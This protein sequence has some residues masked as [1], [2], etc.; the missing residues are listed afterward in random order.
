MSYFGYP[1]SLRPTS[2]INYLS[3]LAHAGVT[4]L[5]YAC[6]TWL[7]TKA[8]DWQQH[9]QEWSGGVSEDFE[10]G[11]WGGHFANVC[12]A[13]ASW[14]QFVREHFGAFIDQYKLSGLYMDN[15]QVY[16]TYACLNSGNW[17]D[18]IEYPMLDQRD[19]YRFIILLR[20]NSSHTFALVHSSGGVN[21]P[22]F[23]MVDAWVSGEQY[24]GIVRNDYLDVASLTDFRIEL[25][26]AQWG[27]VPLFL[28]EFSDAVAREVAPT[29]K[30]M[31]IL[32][33]HDV[34]PWPQ[35]ANV[36][37][38]N[39]GLS[40][41]DAFGIEDAVFI[42][43]YAEKPVASVSKLGLYVSGYRH[44][45]TTLMIVANLSKATL[46]DQLC[47]TSYDLPQGG[48]LHLGRRVRVIE[49]INGCTRIEIPAGAYAM[50]QADRSS[51]T[52]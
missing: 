40:M 39:R 29:R 24:R 51:V 6:P 2:L 19:S 14:K 33:L 28:P 8:P 38:I 32:L 4:G 21:L 9:R 35:W 37:E 13:R 31:S 17:L 1:E 27:I 49:M 25:N 30:L 7:S 42:P 3:N 43:Y 12:P 10:G 41:L 18:A 22:S 15:A 52:H 16:G 50:Y 20:A 11:E 5:P 26:A 23:S 45:A 36:Q 34:T 47:P 44:G 46:V 48:R